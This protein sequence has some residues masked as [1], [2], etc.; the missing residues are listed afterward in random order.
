MVE[1]GMGIAV[2]GGIGV[3]QER[4]VHRRHVGSS[5]RVAVQRSSR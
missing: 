2:G 4:G 3:E 1:E 5:A